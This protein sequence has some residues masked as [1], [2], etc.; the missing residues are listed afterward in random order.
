[1]TNYQKR[2]KT[3]AKRTADRLVRYG[4]KTFAGLGLYEV[5]QGRDGKTGIYLRN[6]NVRLAIFNTNSNHL[7]N[8]L[9]IL[10]NQ[11]LL[12]GAKK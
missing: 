11:A 4:G 12:G 8:A 5:R 2:N 1:M 3:R 7:Q 10:F 6:Y 9:A